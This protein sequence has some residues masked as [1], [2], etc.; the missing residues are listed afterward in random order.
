MNSRTESIDDVKP[1]NDRDVLAVRGVAGVE[2]AVRLYK[3]MVIAR[4]ANGHFRQVIC[5]GWT[6]QRW[7]A[8]RA[9]CCWGAWPI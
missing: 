3:G 1:L 6:M 7:S 4:Q 5:S 9:T 8:R 2:W